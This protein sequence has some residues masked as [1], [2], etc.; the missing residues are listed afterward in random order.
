[1]L[2]CH[3]LVEHK[4]VLGRAD[5]HYL[6]TIFMPYLSQTGGSLTICIVSAGCS[7]IQMTCQRK[8]QLKVHWRSPRI[9]KTAGQSGIFTE[10]TKP[11]RENE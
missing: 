6:Y 5:C 1:M 9:G 2:P 7:G 8:A 4:R 10:M 3:I 11:V